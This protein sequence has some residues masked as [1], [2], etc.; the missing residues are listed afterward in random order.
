MLAVHRFAIRK[1]SSRSVRGL[2]LLEVLISMFILLFGLVG[3]ASLFPVGKFHATQ[4]L[5]YDQAAALGQRAF[6]EIRVRGLLRPDRWNLQNG[7]RFI[8]AYPSPQ[9]QTKNVMFDPIAV[10]PPNNSNWVRIGTPTQ[11]NILQRVTLRAADGTNIPT[12]TAEQLCRFDDDIQFEFP[13]NRVT[14]PIQRINSTERE[15]KGDYTWAFTAI[16]APNMGEG[17]YTVTVV[18]FK[19]RQPTTEWT[20]T[21]VGLGAM[22]GVGERRLRLFATAAQAGKFRQGEWLLLSVP[23]RP[24]DNWYKWFRIVSIGDTST[25]NLV[26]LQT[27]GPQAAGTYDSLINV[28]IF[29]SAVATYEQLLKADSDLDWKPD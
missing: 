27:S 22:H 28:T 24:A 17:M 2:S 23:S 10:A 9:W 25:T 20:A 16:P 4:A 29:G 14:P 6:E 11:V 13:T 26:T 21:T 15:Y 18:V 5:Q 1:R 19:G 8:T 7:T 12:A 3:V